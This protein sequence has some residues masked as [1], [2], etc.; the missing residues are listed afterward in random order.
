MSEETNT[1][2][3]E[4]K[5]LSPEEYK[6]LRD[7]ATKE[8]KKEIAYLKTEKEYHVL[9]ADIEEAKTREYTM[10]ARQ[11][12]LFA[13]PPQP[14]AGEPKEETPP[15]VGAPEGPMPPKRTLKKDE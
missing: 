3:T 2:N 6:K 9:R 8:L 11:A 1:N 12:Q 4:E 5:Q 7:D 15:N 14:P 10:I 13:A